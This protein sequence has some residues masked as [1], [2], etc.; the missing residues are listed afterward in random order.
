MNTNSNTDRRWAVVRRST[1]TKLRSFASRE[2]ARDYKRN[3]AGN[4]GI[5]DTYNGQYVR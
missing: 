5:F 2:A 3:T 1:G 4:I